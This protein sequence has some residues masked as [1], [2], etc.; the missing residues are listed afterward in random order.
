MTASARLPLL[1]AGLALAGSAAS[2]GPPLQFHREI[3]RRDRGD[4]IL[5]VPID[6]PIYAET[7]DGFPDVRILD[8]RDAEVPYAVE[9][10]VRRRAVADREEVRSRVVSLNV[11]EGEALEVVARLE[12][13]APE[14]AGAT[15]R[16][17]LADFERRV[18]VF[19]SRDGQAWTPLID[20]A[21]IFDYSRFMDVRDVD[22]PFAARGFRWFK[23]VFE[24]EADELRSPFHQLS[25]SRTEGERDRRTEV[26]TILRRPF[27]IDRIAFWRTV[28]RTTGEEPA[29]S[30][31]TLGVLKV[32]AD[33]RERET[34]ID[35]DAGRLPLTRLTLRTSSR[36]FHRP[37]RV[38]AEVEEGP[39]GR[40]VDIG[41]GTLFLYQLD[42]F[43]REGLGLD[44]PERRAGRL[45]IVVED[46]DN[47][48]LDVTGVDGEVADH[49]LAFLA[50]PGRTYR[51]AYGSDAL[52][53]PQYDAESVL[54]ALGPARPREV[55]ALGAPIPD[56]GRRPSATQPVRADATLWLTLALVLMTAVLAWVILQAVRRVDKTPL[57]EFDA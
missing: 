46:G 48:P 26:E 9:R 53:P 36:N 6:A 45:R 29:T 10:G 43:R 38:L 31:V 42:A 28:E 41:R 13:D 25:R 14:P 22:V 5:V 3:V 11:V 16:T 55:V 27:R 4:A 51:L 52:A 7:R 20:D 47:P 56:A 18:R 19:G 30:T 1:L 32:E 40:W 44:V 50:S 21:R 12:D 39:P 57:D 49:R 24:R 8:D 17:P 54:A 15:V 37:A 35:V 34:R 2:A 23:L 33:R